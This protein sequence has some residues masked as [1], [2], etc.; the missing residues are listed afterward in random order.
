MLTIAKELGVENNL[1]FFASSWTPPGWMKT[2]TSS[3]KSIGIYPAVCQVEQSIRQ[4]TSS[5]D[6]I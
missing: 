4:K 5:D 1:K 2:A 6:A 3:S